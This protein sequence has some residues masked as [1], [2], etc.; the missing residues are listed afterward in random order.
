[1]TVCMVCS[2]PIIVNVILADPRLPATSE[3]MQVWMPVSPE[4]TAPR[5]FELVVNVRKGQSLQVD[6]HW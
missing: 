3:G 2:S 5:V 6:D 1:M 4:W